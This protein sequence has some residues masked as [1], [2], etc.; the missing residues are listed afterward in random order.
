MNSSAR[1]VVGV[2]TCE[3]PKML[4]AALEHLA[5]MRVPPNAE[6]CILVVD[7]DVAQQAGIRLAE[8]LTSGNYP[9]ALVTRVAS[10]RGFTYARNVILET[11]FGELAADFVAI[12]DDDQ[13]VDTAWLEKA[14]A[15][16]R[17]TDA[18]IVGTAV[19]PLFTVPPS[20]WLIES[21]AYTRDTTTSGVVSHLSG[22]GGVLIS[23]DAVALLPLPWY[24]HEFALSGGA[25]AEV[26]LRLSKHGAIFARSSCAIVY[27][28]Y[29]S[30]R[31]TL[32]WTLK[33][34]FRLGCVDILISRMHNGFGRATFLSIAT[35]IPAI[36]ASLLMIA[37]IPHKRGAQARYMRR[38]A[39]A[40]GKIRGLF[41]RPYAEYA[42]IHGQ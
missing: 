5:R 21:G 8:E 1:I 27:E 37:V 13:L 9:H 38:I 39:R 10:P 12:V 29:E 20:S 30:S 26:F 41:G 3:R 18:T 22:D 31:A 25:D 11:G 6:V 23:K 42:V 40:F 19:I 16:Q 34:A 4:R 35:I 33:R 32:T 2:A 17:N 7:N 24:R 28:V 15:E 36:L 14:L